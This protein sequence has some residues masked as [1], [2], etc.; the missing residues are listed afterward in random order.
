MQQTKAIIQRVRRINPKYQH[1]D[2]GI[3]EQIGDLKAG[4]S[5]LVRQSED[6][7]PYLR[8]RW[9]P[10]SIGPQTLVIE[11]PGHIKYEPGEFVSVLG[12]VGSFFRF[13]QNLRHVLLVAYDTP[14]TPLMSMIPLLLANHTGVTL[15][16]LGEATT[17]QTTHL[18]P[19][20]E[21][22]HGGS[23]LDWEGRV[24]TI[25]LADQIFVIVRPD[26]EIRRFGQ[27]WNMLTELR[28]DIRKNYL[29]GVFQAIPPCGA[30]ACHAC[31]V[32]LQQGTVLACTDGPTLD[33]SLVKLS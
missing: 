31:M 19:Q 8:E 5:L 3:D 11:R 32:R 16:L 9:W 23:D 6:W 25:G 12:P 24:V 13:R 2:L 27:I 14:P 30:G 4:Q 1:V 26:D 22:L 33:L 29:F 28:K 7:Q 17:Y 18:P 21:V 10:V 15:L 20:V